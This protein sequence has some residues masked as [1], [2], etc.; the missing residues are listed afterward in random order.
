MEGVQ[1]GLREAGAE[2]AAERAFRLLRERPSFAD[3]SGMLP[4][5]A[6]LCLTEGRFVCISR[7]RGFGKSADACLLA[8][9]FGPQGRVLLAGLEAERDSAFERFAGRYGAVLLDIKALLA[10]SGS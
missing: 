3:K 5:L 4:R 9:G 7:P 1:R 6:R 2:P 10:A 8:A